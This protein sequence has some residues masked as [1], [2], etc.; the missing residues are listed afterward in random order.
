M[1]IQRIS[2][3]TLEGWQDS[4]VTRFSPLPAAVAFAPGDVLEL[5]PTGATFNGVPAFNGRLPNTAELA[6]SPYYAI[7]LRATAALASATADD[8]LNVQIDGVQSSMIVQVAQPLVAGT[9]S[10]LNTTVLLVPATTQT[11]TI[12]AEGMTTVLGALVDYTYSIPQEPQ[13]RVL[14]EP[15]SVDEIETYTLCPLKTVRP[16]NYADLTVNAG[17]SAATIL[18]SEADLNGAPFYY[19]TA[20][21]LETPQPPATDIAVGLVFNNSTIPSEWLLGPVATETQYL[22]LPYPERIA[23]AYS[24]FLSVDPEYTRLSPDSITSIEFAVPAGAAD[25]TVQYS[26]LIPTWPSQ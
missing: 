15:L 23:P 2:Q 9:T 22:Y 17:A 24:D 6:G 16:A 20:R 18:P 5:T 11:V 1:A 12:T 19:L 25:V 3:I 14:N 21:L 13:N 10:T 8:V 4:P 7:H 26:Y